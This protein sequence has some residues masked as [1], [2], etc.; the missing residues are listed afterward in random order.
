MFAFAGAYRWTIVPLIVGS[1]L[2]A[3]FVRPPAIRRPYRVL[4]LAL[5]ACLVVIA[6][7]LVP[8]SPPM[9]DALSPSAAAIERALLFNPSSGGSA[10][11][12]PLSLDSESTAWALALGVALLLLFWSA[13]ATFARGGGLRLVCRV[14]GWFG[15]VLASV[16]FVQRALTPGLIYGFWQPVTRAS[17]PTPLGPFVNRNDL[18]TWVMLA[19]PLVFGYAVARVE[20]RMATSRGAPALESLIDARTIWLGGAISLMIA[21]LLASLSR[22]GVFGAAAAVLVFAVLARRRL[23]GRRIGWFLVVA[24]ALMA[25][26]LMYVNVSALMLRV[27]DTLPSQL[28]G[29]LTVWRETWPMARDFRWTGIGVGAFER[30]MLVYQQ[31]TRLIFFNHAHDEYLQ[32]LVEGGIL[33]VVPAGIVALAG[34]WGVVRQIRADRTSV[35]WIR[36]GAAS[37]LAAVGAQNIWDTG[38]VMPANAVLFAIVAAAALHEPKTR[39]AFTS[40]RVMP[41]ERGRRNRLARLSSRVLESESCAVPR[42]RNLREHGLRLRQLEPPSAHFG[43]R[44]QYWR[45][46]AVFQGVP[47]RRGGDCLRAGSDNVCTPCADNRSERAARR[48]SRER[49]RCREG[50]SCRFL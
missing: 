15:L 24:A 20:S 6:G 21:A 50:R 8:L 32:L 3:S 14:V 43:L 34:W 37:G 28:G 25:M 18:A 40:K 45:G 38:L 23:S 16:M 41:S 12:R 47:T 9:R 35:F 4:D 29:R 33:L 7:Q 5:L 44:S 48:A 27:S 46:S 42:P 2:V 36:V 10:T 26:A 11:A 49:G 19:C 13:R 17:H 1:V 31:S 30:G 22:S 39:D